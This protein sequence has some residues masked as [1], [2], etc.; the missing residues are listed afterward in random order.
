[1]LA[2]L[3]PVAVALATQLRDRDPASRYRPP[4]PG[5]VVAVATS[6]PPAVPPSAPP[7]D[8]TT[9]PPTVRSFTLVATGDLLSHGSVLDQARADAGG[10]GYDYSRM[11]RDVAPIIAAADVAICHLETPIAPPGVTPGVSLP[12]FGAPPELAAE[13]ARAGYDRCSTASNHALDQRVAG[14]DATVNA[15]EAAGVGQAGMARTAAEALPTRFE[16][17]GVDVAHIAASYGFNGFSPPAAEP[18][19]VNGIDVPLIVDQV[20]AAR[21]DGADVVIVSLHWGIEGQVQPTADQRRVAEALTAAGVDL[22]IGH[23]AH[24]VQPIEQVN[25]TWVVFGLG[26]QLS[27]MGDSTSC[28]GVR[29]LDGLTV[30]VRID[31]ADDG[32]VTVQRPEAIPTFLGRRPY[33]VV[34]LL[35]A[36]ADPDVA[37]HIAR[38]DLEASWSRVQPVIGDFVTQ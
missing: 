10:S 8:P 7:T 30:R 38:R 31:V 37:G 17:N 19:R 26:N 21:R 23:H 33:R 15:L 12:I 5:L 35:D 20:R 9:V 11:L 36:L 29:A 34:P 4:A 28:C 6:A 14:I 1:M 22:I 3:V 13:I 27:G 32:T 18:W 16:V 24:V 2:V 25:G